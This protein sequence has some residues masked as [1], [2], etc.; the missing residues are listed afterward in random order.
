MGQIEI[1]QIM[2]NHPNTWMST[3]CLQKYLDCSFNAVSG[4]ASKLCRSDKRI[5]R[6]LTAEHKIGYD[7]M[8]VP[9]K[10]GGK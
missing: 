3:R 8:F 4:G 1:L 7:Y 9:E 2:K 5:S 6:R 10:L